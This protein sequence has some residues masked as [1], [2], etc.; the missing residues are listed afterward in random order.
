MENVNR[1]EEG[2]LEDFD[3]YDEVLFDKLKQLVRKVAQEKKVPPY[4]VFAE[5]SLIDMATKYPVNMQ[6]F[7]NITGVGQGKAQ[8]FGAPFV[9]LIK[10]YVEENE[11][12]RHV[13]IVVRSTAK[14]SMN[15]LFIIQ[16]IDRRTPLNEIAEM[17]GMPFEEL[18]ENIEHIVFSGTRINIDYY[19]EDV[20]DDDSIDEIYDYFMKSTSESLEVAEKKLGTDYS[21]EEIRMVRIKFISEVGN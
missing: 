13:D 15:K 3:V 11:I 10:E 5:P 2:E 6:E 7:Q 12:D 20:M 1:R 14:K 19:I 17:K 18:L 8:K 9:K 21:L 4:V 16:H